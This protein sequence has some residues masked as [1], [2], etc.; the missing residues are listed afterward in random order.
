MMT[1]IE[2][3]KILTKGKRI[4]WHGV[5]VPEKLITNLVTVR[6]NQIIDQINKY[7]SVGFNSKNDYIEKLWLTI[8]NLPYSMNGD[9][10][11]IKKRFIEENQKENKEK[12]KKTSKKIEV[13]EQPKKTKN[14]NL[15]FGKKTTK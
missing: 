12:V 11:L 13:V 10:Y 8:R 2:Y 7:E 4:D 1:D 14:S 15:I 9:F 5:Q 3:E 6:A